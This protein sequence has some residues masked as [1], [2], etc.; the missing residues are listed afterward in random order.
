MLRAAAAAI[1]VVA[2]IAAAA[3]TG[4]AS[5]A[6][7]KIGEVGTTDAPSVRA[8][9]DFLFQLQDMDAQL[10]NA[11]LVNGDTTV[12]VPRLTSEGLYDRDRQA[13]DG[14]LQAA[15]T[16]LAG[17]QDA[18]KQLHA[19]VDT[20]G[21]Y[22]AQ[23]VRTLDA[24]EREGGTVAGGA[25]GDVISD[26]LGGHA[27][28]FGADGQGGLMQAAT[29][30]EARSAQAIDDSASAA[31]GALNWVTA[32]FVLFGLMLL[33]CLVGLQTFLFLRF[34]RRVNPALAAA[35]LVALIFAV[36]GAA[37]AGRAAGDFRIAKS[38]AFD[39]VLALSQARAVSSGINADE[40]RWLLVHDQP[41]QRNR[42]EQSFQAGEQRIVALRT[43][44]V[45]VYGDT[46]NRVTKQ[47]DAA[48]LP[49]TLSTGSAFGTEFR[50]I[51]FD[52]EMQKAYTAFADYD[53]YIQDDSRLRS[54]PL[55][56]PQELKA[57]IDFDT[58]ADS[59]GSSDRAFNEYTKALDELIGLNQDR[60]DTSMPAAHDGIATWTWLPW[61]LA[62]FVIGLTLLGLRPR[63]AEYR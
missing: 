61:L 25:P 7:S 10:L 15:T 37:S 58:N 31:S 59:P 19:V 51:T 12:H 56:T 34:H 32:G 4:S 46:L 24:D 20:F 2:L 13:A 8:T 9:E 11:L 48:D 35:T 26:Y 18:L 60:F 23:A 54:M 49:S 62:V 39:S 21:R 5:A 45:A 3:M 42:F 17:D 44:D 6:R 27:I 57:A 29:A 50:N 53:V 55:A 22:Q 38:D 43:T 52:G 30:L 14:D 33:S 40:S 28:L 47:T 16:A 1:S 36:G 41:D 63:L